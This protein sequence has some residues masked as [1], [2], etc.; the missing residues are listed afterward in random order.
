MAGKRSSKTIPPVT[1]VIEWETAI[2]VDDEWT[3][4]SMAAL[5]RELA[6]VADRTA[7]KPR[8]AYLYDQ[9]RVVPGIIDTFL[10]K[11]APGLRKVAEVELVATPG[12]SYYKL[13]NLGISRSET[14]FTVVLDSDAAP[15]PGWLE[16]LLKPFADPKVMVVAGFTYLAHE[17]VVSKAMALSWFFDLPEEAA[18]TER[19]KEL[20]ANNF[21]VRTDFFRAHPFPDLPLFKRHCSF[22]LRDLIAEGHG[23]VRT[24]EARAVHAPHPGFKYLMWRGWQSGSDRDYQVFQEKSRSRVARA[25]YAL[26]YLGKKTARSWGRILSKGGKVDLPVWQ[27]PAAMGVALSYYAIGA[28]AEL[29]NAL[30]L[31]YE[32]RKAPEA[33]APSASRKQAA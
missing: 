14:E 24:A 18:E 29:K 23:F 11:A 33:L 32:P 5:E 17:D 31:S 27:R 9:T 26:A 8:V 1:I 15:Q 7:S 19:R 25:G 22:W 16:G 21:A 20:H 13:K 4:S 28:A 12:L 10:D 30:T 6:A 2:D 3:A